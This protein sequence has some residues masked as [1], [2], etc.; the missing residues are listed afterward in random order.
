MKLLFEN[1]RQ[2][3]D[4]AMEG[5]KFPVQIYCD[6]D[7]VLVDFEK[8]ATEAINED[9]KDPER[10]AAMGGNHMKRFNKMVRKLEELG[11]DLEI[12]PEDFS[13]NKDTR[14]PAV[15]NYMYPRFQNDF[16]FWAGLGWMPD[17]QELWNHIKNFDPLPNIL[18]AP[19]RGDPEGGD[20]QGKRMWVQRNLE[21]SDDRVIV[22][23]DKQRYAIA[24]TGEQ[25][26]L[27]DDTYKKINLWREAGGIAIHHQS[28]S[29]SI[30]KLDQLKED[31]E[32]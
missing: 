25:N 20:H 23:S 22:E 26:V 27:I 28:A 7:G 24:E 4:E 15:R 14:I 13:K 8:G 18:T 11:R 21:I 31:Y 6:L 2:F 30:A 17:G 3:I 12:G 1:W 9:L 19:M 16:E 32:E 29:D 10:V 5:N